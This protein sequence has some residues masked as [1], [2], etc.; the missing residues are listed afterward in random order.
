MLAHS[1]AECKF[2]K[3]DNLAA[4]NEIAEMKNCNKVGAI[5]KF[6]IFAV[7]SNIFDSY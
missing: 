1:K 3:K 5:P 6:H 4:I 7:R 2:E